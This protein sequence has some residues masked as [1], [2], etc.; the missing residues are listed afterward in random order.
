MHILILKKMILY[1]QAPKGVIVLIGLNPKPHIVNQIGL[2][3]KNHAIAGSLIGGLPATQVSSSKHNV[4]IQSN[5]LESHRFLS[6][7]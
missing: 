5:F 6:Q 3:F 1:S 7:T 2:L 4:I